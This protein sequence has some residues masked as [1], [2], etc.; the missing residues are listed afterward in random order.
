MMYG[1]ILYNCWAALLGFTV[2]FFIALQEPYAL[3]VSILI[4]SFI[5]ALIVFVC[6]FLVRLFLGYVLFTPQEVALQEAKEVDAQQNMT[7]DVQVPL[8]EQSSTVEFEEDNTEEIAKV[9]RTMMHKDDQ[10]MLGR[11]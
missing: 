9:V 2:Y 10:S 7:E 1:S 5:A 11:L 4:S 3:P 8:R 6:T